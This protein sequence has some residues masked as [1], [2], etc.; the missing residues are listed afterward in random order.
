M[1]VLTGS[2][3][4]ACILLAFTGFG[5]LVSRSLRGTSLRLDWPM[6]AALGVSLLSLLGGFLT[7]CGIVS[8]AVNVGLVG[9]GIAA[10]FLS[11]NRLATKPSSK[12]S[13]S[14]TSFVLVVLILMTA[15]RS[16]IP[17]PWTLNDDAIAYAAFPKKLLETGGLN[18]PFSFRRIVG[19][20]ASPYLNSVVLSLLPEQA[21]HLMD[22]GIGGV[23]VA[24]N[25]R[26]TLRR[27]LATPLWIASGIAMLSLLMSDPRINLAPTSLASLGALC[28]FRSFLAVDRAKL[29]GWQAAMLLA[30]PCAGMISLR[31]NLLAMAGTLSALLFLLHFDS[32]RTSLVSTRL[33]RLMAVASLCSVLLCPWAFALYQSSSTP[34]FPVVAGNFNPNLPMRATEGLLDSAR[35]LLI[36]SHYGAIDLLALVLAVGAASRILPRSVILFGIAAVLSALAMILM[37]TLSDPPNLYRY[38]SPLTL[39]AFHLALGAGATTVTV[40]RQRWFERRPYFTAGWRV[41]AFFVLVLACGPLIA[42]WKTWRILKQS[43][44]LMRKW[45]SQKDASAVSVVLAA[46]QPK[47]P[48]LAMVERADLLDYR[49]NEIF[50]IDDIGAVSPPPGLPIGRSAQSLVVYL[51]GLGIAY[52]LYDRSVE[53]PELYGRALWMRNMTSN[54]L[55]WRMRAPIYLWLF[56]AVDSLQAECPGSF[57]KGTYGVIALAHCPTKVGLPSGL[58]ASSRRQGA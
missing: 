57:I 45:T 12:R 5:R 47:L 18:E 25:I 46:V 7:A 51:R 32:Y 37:F 53:A 15:V 6:E 55:I 3:A 20:G 49:R 41:A 1:Y 35:F 34:F 48:V 13:L 24:F 44:E 21:L 14:A 56:S 26:E 52:L 8:A 22:L 28:L 23:L 19:F 40:W 31:A 50:N 27:D 11:R 29:G 33:V 38:Y 36:N 30:L 16:L 42:P 43:D 39:P 17:E 2:L 4:F 9:V 58:K 54:Q 10:F